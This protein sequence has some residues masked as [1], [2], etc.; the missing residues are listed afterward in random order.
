MDA[1]LTLRQSQIPERVM[2]ALEIK[3]DLPYTI[4]P[5]YSLD[6]SVADLT[7][8]D[9]EYLRRTIAYR[10]QAFQAAVAA[11][12]FQ[13][14]MIGN[15]NVIT[16]VDELTIINLNAAAIVFLVG[17]EASLGNGGTTINQRGG[18]ID[19][20]AANAIS[21]S[22]F[23]IGT[24]AASFMLGSRNTAVIVPGNG[25]VTL[26]DVAVLTGNRLNAS[27]FQAALKVESLTA[28]SP[29]WVSVNWRERAAATSEL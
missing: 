14:G 1:P 19:D 4:D 2:R 17:T 9:Y 27:P 22:I 24:A 12:F 13:F 20:R 16:V 6:I 29:A 21:G 8:F 3:G 23:G 18:S 10:G 5:M 28:N 11:Q 7:T 15:V 26:T 25:S